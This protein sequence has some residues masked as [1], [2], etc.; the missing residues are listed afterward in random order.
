MEKKP[1]SSS[2][3]GLLLGLISAASFIAFFYTGNTYTEKPIK[4]IPALIIFVLLI[5]FII[6][7]AKDNYGNVT[8]GNCFGYGFKMVAVYTLIS[9]AVILIVAFTNP[10]LKQDFLTSV[11]T[12][13]RKTPNF[14]EEQRLQS[15]NMM[16]KFFY[17]IMIG[18]TLISNLIMG[19]I[20]SLIGAAVAK[21]NPNPVPFQES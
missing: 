10:S 3:A 8:F 16:D 15:L 1:I 20:A 7:Y 4:W 19:L 21:K 9:M 2:L 5:V 13:F 17:V 12:Q 11:D 6:K 18:G 14:T